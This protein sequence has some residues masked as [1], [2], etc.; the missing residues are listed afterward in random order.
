MLWRQKQDTDPII[1]V[2]EKV[3]V[4]VGGSEFNSVDTLN[5]YKKFEQDDYPLIIGKDGKIVNK[6]FSFIKKG[7][8]NYRYAKIS[9]DGDLKPIFDLS[10]EDKKVF[11]DYFVNWVNN[12]WVNDYLNLFDVVQEL[13]DTN[14]EEENKKIVFNTYNINDETADTDDIVLNTNSDEIQAMYDDLMSEVGLTNITPYTF[15]NVELNKQKQRFNISEPQY[16]KFL[17]GWLEAFKKSHKEQKKKEKEESEV[18]D[19]DLNSNINDDDI[20]LSLYRSFKALFDKWITRSDIDGGD[21]KMFYNNT[22][23]PYR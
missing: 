10:V 18:K 21:Y 23:K 12:S 5:E 19:K 14:S 1:W 2:D 9:G 13:Y 3:N 22:L 4:V 6:T 15:N 7:D 20:K 8:T 11:I 16:R 17:E